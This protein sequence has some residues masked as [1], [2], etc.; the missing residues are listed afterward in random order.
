MRRSYKRQN[1][2]ISLFLLFKVDFLAAKLTPERDLSMIVFGSRPICWIH[3]TRERNETW[4]LCELRTYKW[5][6]DVIVAVCISAVHIIFICFIPFTGTMNS[7]NWPVPNVWV[8]IAR[9][10]EHYSANA[11][12][13]GSNP[14]E[15]PKTYCDCLNRKNNCY[16][17]NFIS[18][19]KVNLRNR[20]ANNKSSASK[21]VFCQIL[22]GCMEP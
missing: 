4:I 21:K 14:V 2:F 3:R 1:P 8:F 19:V 17:H 12:A 15:A 5:N 22:S 9:L 11:E 10:V 13:M 16:D 6:E 20:T 7:T 18:L